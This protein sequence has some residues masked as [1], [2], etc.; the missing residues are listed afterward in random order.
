M[1]SQNLNIR[2]AR[3]AMLG[4]IAGLMLAG[5]GRLYAPFDIFAHF[6]PHFAF[7]TFSGCLANIVSHRS[8]L[9]LTLGALLT[10]GIHP[11]LAAWATSGSNRANTGVNNAR[12]GT[13]HASPRPAQSQPLKVISLNTW[14]SH[15]NPDAISTFIENQNPDLIILLEFG[16]NKLS[17]LNGLRAKYPHISHCSN[18]WHCS[19]AV[20]SKTPITAHGSSGPETSVPAHAWVTLNHQGRTVTI[21]GAHLHR[22]IDGMKR[23]RKQMIGL[24]KLAN[25]FSAAV[26][27]AGDFNTTKWADS[28]RLFKDQSGLTP[29]PQ[30]IPS[31]PARFPQ[32]AIDHIF[33]NDKLKLIH[34]KTSTPIGSD[35]LPLIATFRLN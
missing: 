18:R 10:L 35:H 26:L 30:Y 33:H 5:L 34:A 23:H 25:K 27:I 19:V 28:Y 17:L 13:P 16:P 9:I 31:W 6:T 3:A 24:S 11:A 21:I 8:G 15:P 20:L 29:M 1:N 2:T 14:H 12:A 7:I 32:L 4:G 22:P